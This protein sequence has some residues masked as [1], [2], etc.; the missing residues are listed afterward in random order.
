M[1]NTSSPERERLGRWSVGLL[2]SDEKTLFSSHQ[3]S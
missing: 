3:Q 2:R 1:C